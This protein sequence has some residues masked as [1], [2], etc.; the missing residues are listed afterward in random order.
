MC[1]DMKD[2]LQLKYIEVNFVDY[3][4]KDIVPVSNIRSLEGFEN[5]FVSIQPQAGSFLLAE[6]VCPRGEWND[7]YLDEICKEIRY[8]EVNFSIVAQVTKHFLVRLFVGVNDL[9][10]ILISKGLMRHTS[11]TTQEAVLLSMMPR[12]PTAQQASS[13]QNIATYKAFTLE[14][15]SQ[16]EV[17]VSYVTDGPCNFSIQLKQSEEVLAK[18]MKEI[19]CM[20]LT[21]IEGIPLPGTVCLARCME[22][23]HICRAVVTNEVDGQYK[24]FYV[25]FGNFEVVPLESLY[26]IPFKFVIPKVMAIRF[27]LAGVEKST[28]TLEM[29][30]AFKQFVDNRLIHMKVMPMTTRTSLPRCELWDPESQISALDIVNQAASAGYPDHISLNRGFSQP[31]KVSYVFSC[32]RFY[33]QLK[34]RL[35]ELV[36]LMLDIQVLCRDVDPLSNN[37]IKKGM[38]CYALYEGDQQWYRSQI[39]EALGGGKAK[40]Q[41]VDYGNEEIVSI[42]LLKPIEGRQLTIL[43]P[44]A[45]ECCLNGYQNMEPDEERDNLLEELI[46]EQ[47]FTMKVVEMQ[48]KKAL[49]ELID[50]ANY[51]V[52]SLLLDKIAVTRSQVSPMLVQAGNKI[53]HRKTS[54]QFGSKEQRKPERGPRQWADNSTENSGWRQDGRGSRNRNN[55]ETNESNDNNSWRQNNKGFNK[56]NDRN[57]RDNDLNDSTDSDR[58]SNKSF[59]RN[60]RYRNDLNSRNSEGGSWKQN[61]RGFNKS[62]D[63]FSRDNNRNDWASG[64][65]KR[66]PKNKDDW[67][68]NRDNNRQNFNSKQNDDWGG[69]KD[70]WK[71]SNNANDTEEWGNAKEGETKPFR[72]REENWTSGRDGGRKNFT[73]RRKDDWSGGQENDTRQFNKRDN[74]SNRENDK[75][76]FNSKDDSWGDTESKPEDSW[77]NKERRGRDNFKTNRNRFDEG[78]NDWNNTET[79]QR[80]GFKKKP[81]FRRETSELSSSGSEKSFRKG[82]NKDRGDNFRNKTKPNF[83]K[84]FEKPLNDAFG[85]NSGGGDTW[86]TAPATTTE[87]PNAAPS[88][89]KFVNLSI[90]NTESIVLISWFHNPTNFYCQIENTQE[91]FKKMMEEIQQAYKSHQSSGVEIGAPVIALFPEDNVLYRAQ[92][93]ETVGKQ[94]KVYYVDFGNVSI[95]DKVWP[96]EMRFM[97]LPAQAICCQLNGIEPPAQSW[98]DSGSFSAYFDKKQFFCRFVSTENDRT[99]VHLECDG[100]DIASALVRDGLAK[101]AMPPAPPELPLLIGQQFRAMLISMNSLADFTVSL[102]SGVLL[103]CSVFNLS[104][105]TVTWESN[106]QEK[107]EQI[108]IVYVDDL[109]EDRLEVTVYDENGVKIKLVNNDEGAYESVELLCPYLILYSSTSGEITYIEDTTVYI[110][111]SDCAE[112]I[113]Y[114]LN[115]SFEFYENTPIEEPVTPVE[116]YLYAVKGSDTNWYRGRVTKIEETKVTVTYVDYG[117]SEEVEVDALRELALEFMQLPIMCIGVTIQNPTE[118]LIGKVVF[119]NL[120][121]TESGLEG[122]I[123]EEETPI[124]PVEEPQESVIEP[125]TIEAVEPTVQTSA[126]SGTQVI[127]SHADSPSDFY[128]QLAESLDVI[129]QLQAS[130]QEQMPEMPDMENSV[131]GVLC[132][133]PYSLDQLW[134]R[135]QVLDADADITTV[136][137]VDYGNTDVL[138]N[139][140]THVKTLPPHLLSLEVHAT[141]C[142]LKIKPIDEEWTS[143][144][145][146]RFDQLCNVETLTAQFLSQDEKTNYV[147]LFSNGINIREVLIEENLALADEILTET[148]SVGFVSHLNSPS[149]FWIQLENCVDELEWVAEQLSGAENFSELEDLAPG[150]LCAALFPDDQMW[151]RARILSNT[152][153]GIEVL[154]VDYGNSCTS[155][156]LRELPEELVIIPPLAQKCSLQKPENLT[157]WGPEMVRKFS[158]ISA[159]GQTTFN[160]KK[161]STGETAVVELLLD[162]VDVTTLLLPK[163]E[164]VRVKSFEG[165]DEMI[166]IKGEEQLQTKYKLESLPDVTW[167][168]ESIKKFEEITD[169]GNTIFQAEFFSDDTIRL[170]L[171]LNDIRLELNGVKTTTPVSS[172]TKIRTE[173]TEID[174]IHSEVT[175]SSVVDTVNEKLEDKQ[176][177]ASSGLDDSVKSD[178]ENDTQLSN[179]EKNES[180]SDVK[181]SN[182]DSDKSKSSFNE[183][184]DQVVNHD[185][186]HVEEASTKTSNVDSTETKKAEATVESEISSEKPLDAGNSKNLSQGDVTPTPLE[187]SDHKLATTNDNVAESVKTDSKNKEETLEKSPEVD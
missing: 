83:N 57:K 152:V 162:G 154:F 60:D 55:Y 18:L 149:E 123:Q 1:L 89:A 37:M 108:L 173:A 87:V 14:P 61:N 95:V 178:K 49:I 68:G 31:V 115:R 6:A 19:N 77:G 141:R 46:L 74:W 107:L 144:A 39:V 113:E 133:A 177:D 78:N 47:E 174:T 143:T 163:T 183:N 72:K 109:K 73:S 104:E 36:K 30:C 8:S 10:I 94:F 186:E 164:D 146:E 82:F 147:E 155:C 126:P 187:I 134:Y 158:E 142:R 122:A 180:F 121:F 138:E 52:A 3:G 167:G 184:I 53:E 166:L 111:P 127:L 13:Q 93:L 23:A 79:G 50:A 159:D 99:A 160:V 12:T 182:E 92:I 35:D 41:Y 22:D 17:Y 117:N 129:E 148:S 11:L 100:E 48:G 102:Q 65:E 98:S 43:R 106:L 40:V 56:N 139:D 130:L 20:T 132:A 2:L 88:T 165:L 169:N 71:N 185:D 131:V 112:T 26:E 81:D 119:V 21:P 85:S 45:I 80:G 66:S 176:E 105:S 118:D 29:Q 44:Q 84:K 116:N 128:L 114:L 9:A 175:E 76:S 59:G 38:P 168:E 171:G 42:S 67:G 54:Q 16:Y 33:V 137:F 153:A 135:A 145:S 25:D 140:K 157:N 15:G 136:R 124:L 90:D 32:N 24:V 172:P 151:Y 64:D 62:Q 58:H 51:N 150:A 75:K 179:E 96:I 170:Y 103:S 125:Q 5:S 110:Q 120:T 70:D 34:T 7:A 63:R 69:G 161:L 86:N 28:V 181:S 101:A 91:A 97:E 27:A 4:H 156:S